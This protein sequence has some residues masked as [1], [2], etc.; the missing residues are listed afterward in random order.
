MILV[1]CTVVNRTAARTFQIVAFPAAVKH[2]L[3]K[4]VAEPDIFYSV[5]TCA[6]TA[7]DF[8]VPVDNFT[9]NWIG[10]SFLKKANKHKR[11][12]RLSETVDQE[13][14][15]KEDVIQKTKMNSVRSPKDPT[16]FIFAKEM[17]S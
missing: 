4:Y 3:Q 15:D 1:I 5:V 14:T 8:N 10:K 7:L 16:D 9:K 13:K 11:F 17:R 2:A 6:I 12:V